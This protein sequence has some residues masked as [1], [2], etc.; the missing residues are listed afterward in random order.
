MARESR[1]FILG[2]RKFKNDVDVLNERPPISNKF[3]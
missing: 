2:G 3:Y 1:V